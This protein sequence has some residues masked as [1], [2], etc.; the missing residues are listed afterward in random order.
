M[1]INREALRT[2]VK[3]YN[4]GRTYKTMV[5][6]H[7]AERLLTLYFNAE[8]SSVQPIVTSVEMKVDL[9]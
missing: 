8:Q 5:E 3:K 2:A 4:H 6:L 1:P 9:P 7:V